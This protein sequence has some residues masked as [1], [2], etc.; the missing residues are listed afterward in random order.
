M[1]VENLI[2]RS[3]AG[4]EPQVYPS[5]ERDLLLMD[6]NTNLIG[7]NPAV[8]RAAKRLASL[9]LQQ[10]PT[11]L[12]DDLRTAAREPVSVREGHQ[13]AGVVGS[14]G[15]DVLVHRDHHF[16]AVLIAVRSGE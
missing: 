13:R 9:D 10:Y 3:L 2:R 11:C 4:L 7:R 16:R 14:L 5:T 15:D 1:D 12:S 6:A 8:D